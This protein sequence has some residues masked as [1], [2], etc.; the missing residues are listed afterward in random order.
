MSICF[1]EVLVPHFSVSP[2]ISCSTVSHAFACHWHLLATG[3]H[4]LHFWMF[5]EHSPLSTASEGKWVWDRPAF[6]SIASPTSL[7]ST[8][9]W[10]RTKWIIW[11][12]L[13]VCQRDE[14]VT[15]LYSSCYTSMHFVF[16]FFVY[17]FIYHFEDYIGYIDR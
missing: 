11:F 14:S 16:V 12:L 17:F 13:R 15:L 4:G 5:R 7:V 2:M 3:H 1:L 10:Q 8:A 6:C 9:S